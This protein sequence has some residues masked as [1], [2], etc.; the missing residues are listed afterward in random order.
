M[1]SNLFKK[2]IATIV[3]VVMLASVCA[4]GGNGGKTSDSLKGGSESQESQPASDS[5][6]YSES[7][8][9]SSSDGG[10]D[11]SASGELRFSDN[12]YTVDLCDEITREYINA[13]TDE[14]EYEIMNRYAG[15]VRDSQSITR[16]RLRAASRL[17]RCA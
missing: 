9:E 10:A 1:K 17:L 3:F 5:E 13:T 6:S 16:K 11:S 7:I 14:Q 8:S 2:F 4:C 12:V 15:T